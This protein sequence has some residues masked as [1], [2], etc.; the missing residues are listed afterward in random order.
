MINRIKNS[1]E[2]IES[3]TR[4]SL[5]T[6]SFDDKIMSSFNRMMFHISRLQWYYIH[7]NNVIKVLNVE[8]T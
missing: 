4:D 7:N 1:I 6:R 3:E 5:K 2:V 8:E